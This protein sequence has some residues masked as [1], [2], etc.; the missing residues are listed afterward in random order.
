MNASLLRTA[1]AELRDDNAQ[2]EFYLTDIVAIARGHGRCVI[3][4]CAPDAAEFA[5]INSREELA[6]METQIRDETNRRLM[7]AG[8]TL[9]D[10]ATAYIAP[11]VEIGRD[12][13]SGPTCRFSATRA[14][15]PTSSSRAPHG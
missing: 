13:T 15:V 3:A 9:I 14:S 6:L 12:T 1:L 2:H 4:W 8:V 5:G 10:P 7:T 11:T